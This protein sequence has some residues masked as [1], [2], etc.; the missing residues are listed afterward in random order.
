MDTGLEKKEEG[1]PG[2]H[3]VKWSRLQVPGASGIQALSVS[4]MECLLWAWNSACP[5]GPLAEG[6]Q[7]PGSR[8]WLCGWL[9]DPGAPTYFPGSKEDLEEHLPPVAPSGRWTWCVQAG[10]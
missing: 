10:P 9:G 5:A 1:R 6:R 7:V 2:R 3:F 8:H 4:H